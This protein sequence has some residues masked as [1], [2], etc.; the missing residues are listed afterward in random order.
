MLSGFTP[1]AHRMVW[2]DYTTERGPIPVP[3]IFGVA[4]SQ[5][6]RTAMIAGKHKFTYFCQMGACDVWS[7]SGNGDDDVTARAV[8]DGSVDLLFVHLPDVDLTG[9]ANG[10][11]SEPYLA[12]VRRADLAVGRIIFSLPH[13]TTVILS[14]DHGGHLAQHGSSDALD[15]TIPWIVAGPRVASGRELSSSIRTVDTAATAPMFSVFRSRRAPP[16]GRCSRRSRRGESLR[17]AVGDRRVT[18]WQTSA[19]VDWWCS[20]RAQAVV[21]RHAGVYPVGLFR[22]NVSPEET[23]WSDSH[24]VYDQRLPSISGRPEDRFASLLGLQV[25]RSLTQGVEGTKRSRRAHHQKRESARE[26]EIHSR[27]TAP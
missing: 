7:I 20:H 13:D 17:L 27:P 3:A 10:W 4:H 22:L 26:D 24:L 2:D 8:R 6:R 15:M 18:A 14:A 12:A 5:G 25:G 23:D 11:M 9:H 21:G 19:S 1:D 16:V